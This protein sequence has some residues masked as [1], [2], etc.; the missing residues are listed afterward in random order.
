MNSVIKHLQEK[1]NQDS[2][3]LRL[4]R[5][6]DSLVSL[7]I[8]CLNISTVAI[9]SVALYKLVDL[10]KDNSI[11]VSFILI[12]L[13]TIFIIFSFFLNLFLAIYRFNTKNALYKKIYNTINYLQLKYQANQITDQELE[14]VLETLWNEISKKK[15]LVIKDIIRQEL[16]SGGKK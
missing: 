11:S 6:L 5:F 10:N 14:T 3:K 13:L 8:A 1:L 4:Y 9:A 2:K 16:Q 12:L 7:V 15:K